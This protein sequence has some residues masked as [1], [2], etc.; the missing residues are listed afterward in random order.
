MP[1]AE[2]QEGGGEGRARPQGR[3]TL[4]AE[5]VE[6]AKESALWR[7]QL[8][9]MYWYAPAAITKYHPWPQQQKFLF[10]QLCG[11]EG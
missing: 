3:G 8:K 4:G 7:I 5:D 1:N 11:L 9:G 10:S 6:R 2:V